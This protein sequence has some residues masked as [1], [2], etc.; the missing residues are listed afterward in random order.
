MMK[1]A[2]MA[3]SVSLF[4]I[5]AGATARAANPIN[6]SRIATVR[7]VNSS[8][9][10]AGT[11]FFI[12]HLYVATCFHVI[13]TTEAVGKVVNFTIGNNIVI[14][15]SSGEQIVGTVV[16]IPSNQ[17]PSPL[18]AD[19]AIIKLSKAPSSAYAPL[20]MAR[21][22]ITPNVGD[23][24]IFSGYPLGVPGMVTHKGM[25]SGNEPILPFI[26]VEAPINNGTSG[27]A[28]LDGH[29]DVIGIISNR[30]GGI[31]P[32]LSALSSQIANGAKSGSVKLMG[33]DTLK[34]TQSLI[35]TLDEY[36][37]TGIGYARRVAPLD[38]YIRSHPDVVR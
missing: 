36:I 10:S 37:S 7:V 5:W 29:G 4:L 3:L 26:I 20:K 18:E 35:Q 30:E 1:K 6:A 19:F 33:I 13:A 38:N 8:E 32:A 17:D 23:D 24:V 21:P 22:D 34:S 27:G 2:L 12:G 25:V 28:L 16:S 11:G 15:M 9:N 31:S 14:Q